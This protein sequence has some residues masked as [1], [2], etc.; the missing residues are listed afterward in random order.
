MISLTLV[1]MKHKDCLGIPARLLLNLLSCEFTQRHVWLMKVRIQYNIGA[2]FTTLLWR[3]EMCKGEQTSYQD[4]LKVHLLLLFRGLTGTFNTRTLLVSKI[5]L[6]VLRRLNMQTC[7]PAAIK[8]GCVVISA[9]ICIACSFS[10]VHSAPCVL[11]TISS[12]SIQTTY[13]GPNTVI[14]CTACVQSRKVF[15][16]A[17]GLP[18]HY[19]LHWSAEN[20]LFFLPSFQL[21]C[22]SSLS[23]SSIP[24]SGQKQIKQYI[25]A[26]NAYLP[27]WAPAS[28]LSVLPR[29]RLERKQM[30]TSRR[31]D[32]LASRSQSPLPSPRLMQEA[33]RSN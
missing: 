20:C 23:T 13:R 2:C 4:Q 31:P 16:V 7:D 17:E 33:S 24:R 25:N 3:G 12:F 10:C 26:Q 19:I 21:V 14:D 15:L 11:E 5:M 8:G 9:T 6:L 30:K 28:D 1:Y 22:Q 29:R 18:L 27:R 32:A